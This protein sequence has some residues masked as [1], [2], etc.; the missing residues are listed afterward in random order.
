MKINVIGIGAGG[1]ARVLLETLRLGSAYEVIGLLDPRPELQGQTIMG[2]CV[3][4]DDSLLPDLMNQGIQYFFLGVGSTSGKHKRRQVY[5]A[6]V[7]HGLT[8]VNVIHPSAIISP[9]AKIGQGA[10]LLACSIIGTQAQL[11][12]NVIVNTGAIVEHD[13]ILESHCHIAPGAALAAEVKVGVET[14]IGIGAVV[15]QSIRIG[16][17]VTVGAGAVVVDNVSDAVTVAG[18]PAKVL[19][20]I[21]P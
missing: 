16:R 18:V 10:I 7:R 9:T 2:V 21:N 19:K 4:G 12:E 14:H 13:C 17:Y 11:G 5:E 8:P 1:H 15:R 6:A 3:L 20:S